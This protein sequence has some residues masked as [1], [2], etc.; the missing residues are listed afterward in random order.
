MALRSFKYGVLSL[1]PNLMPFAIGF[2]IWG[3]TSGEINVGLST[4]FGMTLGIVVDDTVHLLTKYLRARREQNKSPEDAVRYAFSTVGQA[5]VVTTIVLVTGFLILSFS[6]FKMNAQMGLLTS[7]VIVSALVIDLLLLPAILIRA[8][9]KSVT[10]ESSF[11]EKELTLG[12]E[13]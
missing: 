9:K 4:V 6:S 10:S 1:I 13:K 7:I 5:I 3:I 12:F 2:G 11:A 8:N